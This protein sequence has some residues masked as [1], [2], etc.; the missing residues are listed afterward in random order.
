MTEIEL[1]KLGLGTWKLKPYEARYSTIQAIKMGYRHI[2]TAKAYGNEEGVG[3]GLKEIFEAGIVKREEIVVATKIFP[4]A[5]K[6]KRAV[7]ATYKSLNKLQ[8]DY[9]D[10][11]YIHYP[12]FA[13]GYS[14]D[15][16]LGA[17]SVLVEEGII[18]YIGVSNFTPKMITDA[19]KVIEKRIYANQIEHHPYLQQPEV[20]EY[21]KKN[22][23]KQ[24]S[25]SPLGR[26]HVLRDP[27][28]V[29]IAKKNNISEAQVCL[30]WV[31]SKGAYPIPKATSLEHLS[32]NFEALNVQLPDEDLKKIDKLEKNVRYVHPPVVS[33]K[34]WK[35]K[36]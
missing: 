26:A 3:D 11:M 25:Y 2:D 15:K 7:R 20:L 6:P 36:K 33:P 17:L 28:I 19:H 13:L 31:I 35:K 12:A 21:H 34:E 14:H 1:P 30:S 5:L 8:L 10:I 9:I 23:V 18:K 29:D 32:D 4:L 16:T 27:V 24:V 22:N